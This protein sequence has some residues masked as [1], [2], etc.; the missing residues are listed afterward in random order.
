MYT[1]HRCRAKTH[2][3]FIFINHN[4]NQTVLL[5]RSWINRCP[6]RLNFPVAFYR[7]YCNCILQDPVLFQQLKVCC[8]VTASIVYRRCIYHPSHLCH[9]SKLNNYAIVAQNDEIM[10]SPACWTI[11]GLYFMTHIIRRLHCEVLLHT[12]RAIL[13]SSA[14]QI[15]NIYLKKYGLPVISILN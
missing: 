2:L 3:V 7:C 15:K 5:K 9:K 11:I 10:T 13:T 12:L 4:L 6:E 1:I 14:M 8:K